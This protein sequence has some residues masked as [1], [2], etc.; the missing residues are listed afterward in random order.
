MKNYCPVWLQAC[1]I[2]PQLIVNM[3]LLLLLYLTIQVSFVCGMVNRTVI[4]IARNAKRIC[5]LLLQVLNC[6]C[7]LCYKF[8]VDQRLEDEVKCQG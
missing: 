3:V 8:V 4:F 6:G 1:F 5:Y 2:L 7:L